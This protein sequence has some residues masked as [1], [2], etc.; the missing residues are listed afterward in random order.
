M[1]SA[2]SK[3]LDFVVFFLKLH[4]HFI[5]LH[6]NN[7]SAMKIAANPIFHE[8]TKYMEVDDHIV[9]HHHSPI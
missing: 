5:L 1:P 9:N 6:E 4:F 3:S 2:S 8:H 7:T